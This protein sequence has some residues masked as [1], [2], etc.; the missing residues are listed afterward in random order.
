M[1]EMLANHFFMARKYPEAKKALLECLDLSPDDKSI[2]KKL[3]LCF[4]QTGEIEE[5]FDLLCKLAMEDFEFII[6]TNPEE[7][8]CPC[9]ELL[10]QVDG[11]AITKESRE[12]FLMLG[13][14]WL[15]CDAYTSLGYFKKAATFKSSDERLLIVINK[16]LHHLNKE[17]ERYGKM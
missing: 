3:I 8:D 16:I 2:I 14:I 15:Y 5:G 13:I 11:L 4:T 12:Y 9:I 17:G 1:N 10:N 7:D 6:N